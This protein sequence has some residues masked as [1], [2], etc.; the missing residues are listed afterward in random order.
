M[1]EEAIPRVEERRGQTGTIETGKLEEG[2]MEVGLTSQTMKES[3]KG[4]L[5]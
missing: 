2:T 1:A 5:T 4:L 3:E